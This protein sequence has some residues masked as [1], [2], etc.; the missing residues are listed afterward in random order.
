MANC[1]IR[2]VGSHTERDK[3]I[4]MSWFIAA[5]TVSAHLTE[6]HTEAAKCRRRRFSCALTLTKAGELFSHIAAV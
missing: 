5:L 4:V 6:E 3:G 1:D 2:S